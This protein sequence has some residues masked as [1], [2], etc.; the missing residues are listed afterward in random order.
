MLGIIEDKKAISILEKLQSL[1]YKQKITTFFLTPQQRIVEGIQ[2]EVIT[3]SAPAVDFL[4][5]V[6]V[7]TWPATVKKLILALIYIAL[8]LPRGTKGKIISK[9][10]YFIA[11]A[12]TTHDTPLQNTSALL[13]KTHGPS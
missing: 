3:C 1:I 10:H 6:T 7:P 5:Q 9:E 11:I 13:N 2:E 12:R 8:M 4:L